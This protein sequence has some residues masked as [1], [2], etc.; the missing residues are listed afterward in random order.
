[1]TTPNWRMRFV[2]GAA[3][4]QTTRAEKEEAE[5]L[6]FIANVLRPAF[7]KIARQLAEKGRTV[8]TQETRAACGI[9][10]LNGSAE[11]MSF[12]IT[13]Q[14]LPTAIVPMVEV[15]MRERRGLRIHRKTATLRNPA[16][17]TISISETTV[18]DVVGC[19]LKYY[20]EA[21]KNLD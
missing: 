21:L 19:F 20:R 10:I 5:F 1:M 15:K 13:R 16:E 7:S 11:E 8:G 18:D 12:R 9:T 6:A 4:S 3:R 17:E 14:S 2:N